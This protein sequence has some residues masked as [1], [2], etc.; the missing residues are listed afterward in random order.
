MSKYTPAT[1]QPV[2]RPDWGGILSYLS[3]EEKASILE[4]IIK[5]PSVECKSVFWQE[6]IK[7]DLDLQYEKFIKQCEAK[8]RAVRNRWVKTSITPLIEMDKTSITSDEE[9]NNTCNRDGIV[10]E[11]E[12]ESERECESK[13]KSEKKK[14]QKE[15]L[16]LYGEFKHVHLTEEYYEHLKSNFGEE[17]L[18]RAIEKLDGWL[19]NPKQKSKRNCNHRFYFKSGGWVWEVDKVPK[20][21]GIGE[22]D[23]TPETYTVGDY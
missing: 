17:K 15:K 5:Y 4:A 7:P 22:W 1:F 18:S 6:T 14:E 20:S 16:N 13:S 23:K 9:M 3:V 12:S 2:I 19:D 10:S 11:S 21:G 8:S